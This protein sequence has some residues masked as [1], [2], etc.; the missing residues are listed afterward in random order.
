[1]SDLD[2]FIK[3]KYNQISSQF[4]TEK[5]V[6][7]EHYYTVFNNIYLI[8]IFA[9]IHSNL[10][11]LFFFMN[12]KNG[13]YGGHYN[14]AESRE[15]IDLIDQTRVL[16]AKLTGS[17]NFEVDKYYQE[18]IDL[19]RT[20]LSQSGGSKIPEGFPIINLI[21]EKPIFTKVNG[22]EIINHNSKT[23]TEIKQIGGGSYAKVF[24]YQDP[25]Y[26]IDFALKRANKDL[27]ADELERFKNEFND[28]K[29][30]DS[31]F[32]IKAYTYNSEKNEYT[33][34]LADQTL[35]RFM[36]HNNNSLSFDSRRALIIQ[37]LNA[38]SYI[39]NKG[40]LHRD[41]S[42][43]N[44]LVKKFEDGSFLIKVSDFGL[45]KRPESSLTR[46]GTEIKGAINDYSNL[47][48]VGFENYEIRHE[49]Y[50]LAKVIYYILTGR[51][52][53]YHKEEIEPLKKF[54]LKAIGDMESR[55]ND[56][57]DLKGALLTEVFPAVR[58][59]NT[60]ER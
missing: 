7:F 5:S 57:D 38:F 23:Y 47:E 43:Q 49:T 19:C 52:T 13:T 21:E 40:L 11:E 59:E 20:F 46:Q 42:Y 25:Y 53:N 12:S 1:M 26:G 51:E 44:I 9:T 41:I 34:E 29:V 18:I 36:R 55:F 28:L 22:V 60:K 14:A 56:I 58:R 30:L 33:M 54:I 3:I 27:R 17:Y 39:H 4:N 31:P 32:I 2:N 48:L 37:L 6:L 16:K 8:K 50:A 24:R 15:L 35:E 45:V 10:N